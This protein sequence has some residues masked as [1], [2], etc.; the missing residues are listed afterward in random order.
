[1]SPDP[2]NIVKKGSVNRDRSHT[3]SSTTPQFGDYHTRSSSGI[4][5]SQLEQLR[6][7]ERELEE[8]A[9]T[10]KMNEKPTYVYTEPEKP[11]QP[12]SSAGNSG[13]GHPPT[14]TTLPD[15]AYATPRKHRFSD[16]DE[17]DEDVRSAR[18]ASAQ[19][20]LDGSS[21]RSTSTSPPMYDSI[22]ARA[23]K[24]RLIAQK[25]RL[26]AEQQK[27]MGG[28]DKNITDFGAGPMPTYSP[29]PP[30]GPPPKGFF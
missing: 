29:P 18:R 21:L 10:G 27:K 25:Q 22:A 15:R 12:R 30:P 7:L 3:Y 9:R 4:E 8:E 2:L 6:E 19:R 26:I 20:K 28:K 17:D 24:Q 11:E 14:P 23:E 13:H 16:P 1:M 5:P